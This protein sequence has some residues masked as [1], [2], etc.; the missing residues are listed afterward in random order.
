MANR[1][2]L[3]INHEKTRIT[4]L[5]D[6]FD[7]IGYNFVKRKSPKSGRMTIYIFPSKR[8]QQNIR[9][10]LKYLTN[11]RAPIKPKE[12]TELVKP[13]VMGWVN[14]FKHTNASDAFRRLQ[15]FINTR[16]RRYLNQRGKGRGFGWHRF[17]NSMLYNMGIVYIG[18]GMVEY[19]GKLAHGLR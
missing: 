19:P 8:A 4:K 18:S 2:G 10:R 16:F 14:Y 15:R 11:R 7:F 3:V 5:I 13:V 12:F 9:N 6:G 1:M 17:P